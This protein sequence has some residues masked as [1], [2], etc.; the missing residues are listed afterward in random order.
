[1]VAARQHVHARS[2]MHASH[3]RPHWVNATP[4]AIPTRPRTQPPTHLQLRPHSHQV[5]VFL[6]QDPL[7]SDGARYLLPRERRQFI[8]VT[9]YV[10]RNAASMHQATASTLGRH[11]ATLPP[12]P[13]PHLLETNHHH[14]SPHPLRCCTEGAPHHSTP[15]WSAP[16]GPHPGRPAS[17]TPM[18]RDRAPGGERTSRRA[19]VLQG[20][21][22]HPHWGG[23]RAAPHAFSDQPR[24]NT[25][26]RS[27]V[28]AARARA[29]PWGLVQP[30]RVPHLPKKTKRSMVSSNTAHAR[31]ASM[32]FKM[33]A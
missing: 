2:H 10:W 24:A 26:T 29:V 21:A 25:T 9:K 12:Q 3:R 16:P 1:M 14:K 31:C 6:L 18:G 33:D 30:S 22:R 11:T 27:L 19:T 5:F 15:S 32:G 8:P 17:T 13:P 28:F 4:A 23:L 7:L 20:H